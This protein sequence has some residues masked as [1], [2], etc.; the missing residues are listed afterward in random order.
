MSGKT[1]KNV[2]KVLN[3]RGFRGIAPNIRV[4]DHL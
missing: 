3:N 4:Y 1:L 2:N